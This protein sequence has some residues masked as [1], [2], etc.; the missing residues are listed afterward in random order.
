VAG[1]EENRRHSDIVTKQSTNRVWTRT[2]L[3]AMS[4][5]TIICECGESEA[6]RLDGSGST[7]LL[8]TAGRGDLEAAPRGPEQVSQRRLVTFNFSA[9]YESRHARLPVDSGDD[10]TRLR[11]EEVCS[12]PLAR[13]LLAGDLSETV[14]SGHSAGISSLD[15]GREP[16]GTSGG[17]HG[18]GEDDLA[19]RAGGERVLGTS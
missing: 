10:T 12:T 6:P 11:A 1:G 17:C 3:H 9:A 14:L 19:R 2:R 5:Q 4:G 18:G 13:G 8:L 15:D 7:G 16:A